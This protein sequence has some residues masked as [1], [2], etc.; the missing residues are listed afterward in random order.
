MTRLLILMLLSC[1]GP[2]PAPEVPHAIMRGD[3]WLDVFPGEKTG[4]CDFLGT[5]AILGTLQFDDAGVMKSPL[6]GVVD[7]V[8]SYPGG[9][10]SFT[11]KGLGNTLNA[12]A[13]GVGTDKDGGIVETAW[14]EGSVTGNVDGC[15]R[16]IF[17][18]GMRRPKS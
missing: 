9:L 10:V 13:R 5:T 12:D 3:Y 6:E 15:R 17:G 1:G 18:F 7:C 8:T 11:C 14:G 2:L 16:M 4:S